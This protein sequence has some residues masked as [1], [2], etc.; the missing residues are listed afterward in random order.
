[1]NKHLISTEIMSLNKK[2]LLSSH[3]Q[4]AE[5]SK[6]G[7]TVYSDK[8]F[9]LVPEKEFSK[10]LNQPVELFLSQYEMSFYGV[11]TKIMAIKKNLFKIFID[12]TESTPLYYREC[13]EDLL[14]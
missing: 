3:S 13:V 8:K 4:L 5:V 11:I 12:F 9:F 1:M 6:K 10:I 7:L 2:E 14:N